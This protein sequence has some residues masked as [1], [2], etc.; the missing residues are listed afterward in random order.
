VGNG[1]ERLQRQYRWLSGA[2]TI[3]DNP[4]LQAMSSYRE[5]TRWFYSQDPKYG[6]HARLPLPPEVAV[7]PRKR[8]ETGQIDY[9]RI[10]QYLRRYR[11]EQVLLTTAH[12]LRADWMEFLNGDYVKVYEDLQHRLYVSTDL[13]AGALPEEA[14][15]SSAP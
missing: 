8:F 14:D 15:V 4:V 5:H 7:L 6:F 1:T 9:A 12:E 2:A 10:L 3:E 11:P 13:L